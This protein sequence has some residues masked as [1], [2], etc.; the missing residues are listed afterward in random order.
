MAGP[1]VRRRPDMAQTNALRQEQS[2]DRRDGER[3]PD[4]RQDSIAM[5]GLVEWGIVDPE[6]NVEEPVPLLRFCLERE[7][8]PREHAV[9][10]EEIISGCRSRIDKHQV[11]DLAGDMPHITAAQ[12]AVAAAEQARPLLLR[13]QEQP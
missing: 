10:D 11:G 5:A 3:E 4:E 6:S 7:A 2:A 13:P 9:V 12:R 1:P 8:T